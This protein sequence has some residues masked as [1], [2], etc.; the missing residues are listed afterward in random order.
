MQAQVLAD[1]APQQPPV[2]S[3]VSLLIGCQISVRF[4]R[5]WSQTPAWRRAPRLG[6]QAGVQPQVLADLAPQQPSAQTLVQIIWISVKFL[7]GSAERVVG[8][9]HSTKHVK[10]TTVLGG[11]QA[12][13]RR[14]R[15]MWRRSNRLRGHQSRHFYYFQR[16][17]FTKIH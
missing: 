5:A 7:P 12:C 15:P 11:R 4:R 1:V 13:S 8:R 2:Q 3:P 9:Q 17:V 16:H 14:Y 6:R 10:C